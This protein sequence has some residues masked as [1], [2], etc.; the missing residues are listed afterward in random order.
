V[1]DLINQMLRQPRQQPGLGMGTTIGGGIAGVASTLEAEGIKAYNDRTK[2]NEWEFIYDPRKDLTSALALPAGLNPTQ[3][4]M[5]PLQPG[6][7]NPN[8]N[9]PIFN[10][11]NKQ[12]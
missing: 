6:G 12:Q 10:P 1:P 4:G 7:G 2:Y 3:P 5:N 8:Q 9:T 11:I